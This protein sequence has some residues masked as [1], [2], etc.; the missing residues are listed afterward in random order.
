MVEITLG[1]YQ[2]VVHPNDVCLSR[3]HHPEACQLGYVRIQM[4]LLMNGFHGYRILPTMHIS[5]MG[6]EGYILIV[7]GAQQHDQVSGDC[8]W[9]SLTAQ[10]PSGAASWGP[11]W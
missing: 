8:L 3:W 6:S 11:W 4:A 7:L 2:L 9:L 10:Q 1:I 5:N